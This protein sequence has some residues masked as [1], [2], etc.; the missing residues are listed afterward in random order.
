M[1]PRSKRRAFTLVELLVVI[2]IIG[3]LVALLLPA[4][5]AAREAARRNS[6]INRLKNIGLAALNVETATKR[7]PTAISG[8][9]NFATGAVADLRLAKPGDPIWGGYSFYMQLLPHMEEVAIY[10]LA[11][12]N[13]NNFKLNAWNVAIT[14]SNSADP[15]DRANAPHLSTVD[16]PIFRCPSFS[17]DIAISLDDGTYIYRHTETDYVDEE[18]RRLKIGNYV[19]VPATH[20]ARAGGLLPSATKLKSGEDWSA[21]WQRTYTD[22]RGNGVIVGQTNKAK[23]GLKQAEVLDGTSKSIMFT[24]S[25]EEH[26]GSWYDGASMWVVGYWPGSD[27]IEPIGEVVGSAAG[28]V[29]YVQPD[30]RNAQSRIALNQGPQTPA[31]RQ[32]GASETWYLPESQ[33]SRWSYRLNEPRRWGPSSEH[34]GGVVVHVFADGH[35]EAIPDSIDGGAYLRMITRDGREPSER[36]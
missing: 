15:A 25:R 6:C 22:S 20:L 7:Y 2:A 16:I 21:Q 8:F 14:K 35:T 24:E 31:Q 27:P 32:R 12:N 30:A 26:F 4:I 33:S 9:R 18:L 5:Q 3:I 13:S 11:R 17:G 19:C 10:D 36:D 1:S 29:A 28:S 34:S 23:K